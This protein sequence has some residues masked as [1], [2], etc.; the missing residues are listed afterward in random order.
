MSFVRR[1]TATVTTQVERWVGALE[2]HEAI[3]AVALRDHRQALAA[4]QVRHEQ[5]RQEGERLRAA[6]EHARQAAANWRQRALESADEATALECLRRARGDDEQCTHL[7]ATLSRHDAVAT[8]LAR[9]IE[10]ARQRLV[11]LNHRRLALRGRASGAAASARIHETT[12]ARW[13]LDETFA[14]WEIQVGAAELA[15]DATAAGGRD[16][17]AQEFADREEQ[18][19][20]KAELERLQRQA[21]EAHHDET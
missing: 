21:R 16:A 6:H 19:A 13:D 14:R 11:E 2:N 8:Q 12:E 17:F 18:A 7:A 20:L 10:D 4:A 9:T 15:C 5:L 1:L 3:V